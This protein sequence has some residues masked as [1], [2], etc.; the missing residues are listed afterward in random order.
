MVFGYNWLE[1][2]ASNYKIIVD[3]SALMQQNSDK[4]FIRILLPLLK[5]YNN[6]LILPWVVVE[7]L[8]KHKKNPEKAALAIQG[9]K[10]LLKFEKE[11]FLDKRGEK[12][13]YIPD[14]VLQVVLTK[15]KVRYNL[16]F[17]T[18]DR[19][20][21][22][23]LCMEYNAK[24]VGTRKSM[25]IIS[26]RRDGTAFKLAEN[27]VMFE[28]SPPRQKH[29]NNQKEEKKLDFF[30]SS[31][32]ENEVRSI[33]SK[34]SN[35]KSHAGGDGNRTLMK[36]KEEDLTK[37]L[38]IDVLA[39]TWKTI[40]GWKTVNNWKEL[41]GAP[42]YSVKLP[43]K[44]KTS[45]N[46]PPELT[47]L[48]HDVEL[49]GE[50]G[51]ARIF[52]AKR[53]RDGK[54]VAV[55]IPISLDRITGKSFLRE[56]ENWTKL[57]HP[58][59]VKVYDYNILPIPYVEMELCD[60]SLADLQKP[61]N[62]EKA[63][64]LIFNIAE[65]LK[66]AHSMGIIHRDLKPQNILVKDGIPKISD[67]GL[68]KIMD[69]SN[70]TPSTLLTP[71]Y[72]APEQITGSEEDH[73]TDIWHLGVVFYELVT[74]EVPFKGDNF[75]DIGI[76]I[77]TK[78]PISPSEI[79]PK[80]KELNSTILKCLE[81]DKT[82]RYQ[83][84]EELQKDLASYLGVHYSES[85]KLSK[86]QKN[87]KKSAYYCGELILI[88]LKIGELIQAYKFTSDM[89]KY[90]KDKH[91]KELE[92]FCKELEYRIENKIGVSEELIKKAEIIVYRVRGF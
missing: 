38:P 50:G 17:I 24:S 68:S 2:V 92:E 59:I 65:G 89:L 21:A 52:K 61:V 15:F 34:I 39:R 25:V 84:V 28:R 85:L 75:V 60:C 76:A 30:D 54:E 82:K 57:E 79:N 36:I 20:L 35:I 27:G 90:A 9:L 48:F 64:W 80:A 26:V 51:F 43:K 69:E 32:F 74:G 86:E 46:F 10:I 72:A 42:I 47:E 29:R 44:P 16:A 5:K 66:Y 11:G 8:E 1:E 22:R 23:D 83:S 73:R 41:K 31:V 49:I 63:T 3:T 33:N 45:R 62:A 40:D 4:F 18:N 88:N 58:N 78:Q 55:K 71:L 70:L 91:R 77:T 37:S 67:W 56:I 7:E 19:D 87:F 53:K 13:D 14:Q 6:K 81:K 12:T